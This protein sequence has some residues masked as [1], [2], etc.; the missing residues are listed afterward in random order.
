M[1]KI[2]ICIGTD[3]Q[4]SLKRWLFWMDFGVMIYVIIV[5][6][7]FGLLLTSIFGGR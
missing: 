7:F 4:M 2:D 6:S 1:K 3:R 5:L